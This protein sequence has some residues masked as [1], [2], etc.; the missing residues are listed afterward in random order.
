M[1]KTNTRRTPIAAALLA[2]SAAPAVAD[3][4]YRDGHL[5]P[6]EVARPYRC[7]SGSTVSPGPHPTGRTVRAALAAFGFSPVWSGARRYYRVCD[8][9]KGPT[10]AGSRARK[11]A[12]RDAERKEQ[13]FTE[14]NVL[15]NEFE[16]LSGGGAP[17]GNELGSL[18]K[19]R[20]NL[21]EPVPPAFRGQVSEPSHAHPLGRGAPR[22]R[23]AP[24][25]YG[26]RRH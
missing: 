14:E 24:R 18:R 6:V 26:A 12:E 9:H 23:H 13:R 17:R 16:R 11:E 1:L 19:W 8:L 10:Q 3:Y 5:Y 22:P 15:V 4:V 25:P 2:A 7:R 21:M 20:L